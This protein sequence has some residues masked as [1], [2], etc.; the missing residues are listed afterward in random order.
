MSNVGDGLIHLQ[1]LLPRSFKAS[2]GLEREIRHLGEIRDWPIGSSQALCSVWARLCE[3]YSLVFPPKHSFV[4]ALYLD[5]IVQNEYQHNRQVYVLWWAVC[6]LLARFSFVWHG[7]AMA[8]RPR[9][10]V[11]SVPGPSFFLIGR[12]KRILGRSAERPR[13]L[14][15]LA[16]LQKRHPL[17]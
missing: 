14:A 11:H 13:S 4:T 7:L 5:Q 6:R 2:D 16:N 17:T 15:F 3:T 8:V 9:F 1:G 10:P 12:Q